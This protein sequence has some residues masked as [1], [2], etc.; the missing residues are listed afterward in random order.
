MKNAQKITVLLILMLSVSLFVGC[1]SKQESA[2]SKINGSNE[3]EEKIEDRVVTVYCGTELAEDPKVQKMD[4]QF[5]KETGIKVEKVVLPGAGAEVY[6][7]IKISLVAGETTD[8]FRMSSSIYQYES[9]EAGFLMPLNDLI[10]KDNYDVEKIY[11]KYLTKDE[12]GM[13]NY[14]PYS[15]SS[16]A[17]FYNK[18]IFDEAGVPYPEGEW[19][20][21]E[22]IETAK[23]L[24]DSEKG[25][26]GS[27]M[28]DYDIYRYFLARQKNVS[29]Y[30]EDGTSN[31]D[32]PVFA[33]SMKFFGDLGEGYKVQPSYLEFTTKKYA[34]DQFMTGEFGMHFIGSWYLGLLSDM[35]K[36]P[37]DWDWGITQLPTPEDG[38]NNFGNIAAFGINKNADHPEEAFEYLKFIAENQA[39]YTNRVPARADIGK[40]EMLKVFEDIANN[41]GG[42]VT[43][44]NLYDALYDNGLGFVTEKIVGPAAAEYSSIIIQESELYYVGEQTLDETV[45]SISKRVN[46]AIEDS[47]DE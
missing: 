38:K 25:I 5:T 32:D 39:L 23:K 6:N 16:W 13:I 27:Y 21:D 2:I 20:W 41:S 44:E 31:Y 37:R 47:Q 19:T 8:V 43:A 26:Y 9:A 1:S 42:S 29:A 15:S 12:N 7:K 22:Y 33:E 18:K 14:L 46:K 4:E 45:E 34:W 3:N 10:K 30:K 36:Y 28:L 11:G 17:V 24:T 40:E 35:E